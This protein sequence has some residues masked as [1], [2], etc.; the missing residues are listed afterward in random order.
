MSILNA[1]RMF[2]GS[3]GLS[4]TRAIQDVFNACSDRERMDCCDLS[5]VFEIGVFDEDQTPRSACSRY[6][7]LQSIV[8][9]VGLRGIV[10]AVADYHFDK[11]AIVIRQIL[12]H[13]QCRRCGL[14]SGIIRE[15]KRNSSMAR[16]NLRVFVPEYQTGTLLFLKLCGFTARPH[17]CG[18]FIKE[19]EAVQ[20]EYVRMEWP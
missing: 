14:G 18:L 4:D 11:T 16:R 20:Q 1:M 10:S 3:S 7:H 5:T 6:Y 15:M 8:A 19:I 2:R 17:E 9:Q 12:V 13:P